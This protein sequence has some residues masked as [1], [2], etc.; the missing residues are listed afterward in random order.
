M[1]SGSVFFIFGGNNDGGYEAHSTTYQKSQ[2][3]VRCLSERIDFSQNPEKTERGE[4]VSGKA[5]G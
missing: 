5:F 1:M 2:S 3:L 4:L